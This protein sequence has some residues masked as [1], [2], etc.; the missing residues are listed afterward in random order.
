M[1]Y[2]AIDVANYIVQMSI[3]NKKPLSNLKLQ[4]ILYYL[5]ARFLVETGEP[6]FNDN[7]EKWKY[8]PVIPSVYHEFKL[9]GSAAIEKVSNTLRVVRDDSNNVTDIRF[10]EFNENCIETD[11]KLIIS[12]TVNS[13]SDF[14]AFELVELTHEH[15]I[16]KDF[17][18]DISL[19]N[20]VDPYGNKEL[21]DF[22]TN[23]TKE[24]L[25]KNN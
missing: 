10:E 20:P 9:F 3:Q 4:K 5:Q 15:S 11:D 24:Q 1:V 13:L 21:K 16:W 2:R 19:N 6:I 8:G 23:N 14:G 18:L 25:W 22:F 17:E 12:Q 7:M